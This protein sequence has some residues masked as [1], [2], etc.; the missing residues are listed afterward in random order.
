MKIQH[1]NSIVISTILAISTKQTS[2]FST[3]A[4]PPP[5][6]S[7]LDIPPPPGLPS[8]VAID[9]ANDGVAV[10]PNYACSDTVNLLRFDA[11][12]LKHAGAIHTA[13]T[14][15][16]G[17]NPRKRTRSN[18]NSNSNNSSPLRKCNHFWLVDRH[19]ESGRSYL[20]PSYISD[21]VSTI[22]DEVEGTSPLSHGDDRSDY[23]LSHRILTK[24]ADE[25][26]GDDDEKDGE[27][28]IHRKE[29]EAAYLYYDKGGYYDWHFDTPSLR[30][31]KEEEQ[32]R[33]GNNNNEE[34]HRRAFSFLLYLGGHEAD[35]KS[36]EVRPWDASK[37]G[38]ELRVFPSISLDEQHRRIVGAPNKKREANVRNEDSGS[39]LVGDPTD[40]EE[41][42]DIVPE[43]GTLVIFKSEAICHQ[44]LATN[45][46]RLVVVGWIHGDL[47]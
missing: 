9:L 17:T 15:G 12:R 23:E 27:H 21:L 34:N 22:E 45:R 24:V 38:G 44:V 31:S 37:D 10:V 18:S 29:T 43:E 26:C 28:V 47:K 1:S 5:L 40:Q 2:S 11:L 42:L 4:A 16:D 6:P 3:I 32:R 20:G 41:F 30:K 25:Y 39:G 7:V 19:S 13:G 36:G 46:E 14:T 35:P 33:D 8:F